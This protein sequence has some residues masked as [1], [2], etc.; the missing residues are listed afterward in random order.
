MIRET[1]RLNRVITE[2]LEFARPTQFNLKS[3]DINELLEHSVRLIHQ[4]ADTKGITIKLNL[5][6]QQVAVEIDSD[7]FSQCLLNLYLNALQ[8]MNNGGRLFI[9]NS[10]TD[11]G[12]IKIEI[13]DTG[14]GIKPEDLNKIFDP[15]FT[16]KTKGTGLGLAIVHNI[17]EAHKGQIKVRSIPGQGTIFTIVIPAE[18]I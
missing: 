1:D 14:S 5:L 9:E 15:Y 13:K 16:T 17:I 6:R 2:L 10:I 8:A 7:R 3:T 11:V 4:E 18:K 12:H